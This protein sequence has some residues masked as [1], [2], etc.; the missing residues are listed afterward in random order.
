MVWSSWFTFP[1]L[2]ACL[3]SCFV[4]F[5]SQ[6]ADYSQSGSCGG[7]LQCFVNGFNTCKLHALRERDK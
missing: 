3:D 2:R 4:F 6:F 1:K 5:A 7:V